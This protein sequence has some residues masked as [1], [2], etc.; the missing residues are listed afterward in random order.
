ML[1]NTTDSFA[2]VPSSSPFS[3][4]FGD[5]RLD[6]CVNPRETCFQSIELDEMLLHHLPHHLPTPS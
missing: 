6:L 1:P 3:K 4:T 2:N 5:A